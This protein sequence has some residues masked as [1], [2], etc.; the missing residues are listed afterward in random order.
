MYRSQSDPE[1]DTV[2]PAVRGTGARSAAARPVSLPIV[3]AFTIG[4]ATVRWAQPGRVGFTIAHATLHAVAEAR[5]AA[6]L[7][8]F[9]L[10]CTP[11][12]PV[13]TAVRRRMPVAWT[14]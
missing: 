14:S 1:L 2:R 7:R 6:Q 11:L 13:R 9:F 5:E 8:S 12:A 4:F 10:L 3:A